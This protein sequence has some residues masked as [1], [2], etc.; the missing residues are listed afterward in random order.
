MLTRMAVMMLALAAGAAA[1]QI[2]NAKVE[3][4]SAAAGLEKAVADIAA[5]NAVA[6]I[7]Y[8]VPAVDDSGVICC[9]GSFDGGRNGCCGTCKLEGGNT[10][11]NHGDMECAGQAESDTI[12]VFLRAAQGRVEKV[13]AF[14][15]NCAVDGGGTIVYTLE[16]VKPEESVALL[17]SLATRSP[18]EERKLASGAVMAIAM[19]AG[20]AA[21]RALAALITSENRK[22]RKDAA[23]WAGTQRGD[24]GY[25]MLKSAISREQDS[26]VRK[27][28]VFPLAQSK[29][30]A[31]LDELIRVARRDGS[32]SVRGEAIFWLGQK[33]SR[34]ASEAI[35]E[36]I[37][38]DPET[39]VKKKAVFALSNLP[40][41]E[42]V[43]LLIK[44]ARTHAN[45]VVR[46]QAIFWLG[47]SQD[48][49]ALQFFEE[50]LK[51]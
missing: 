46:K 23:F 12:A 3:R 38:N 30:A 22:L 51:N 33:A 27:E 24:A 28:F 39:Q 34:K 14:T 31:A 36:A 37:E 18:A 25:A 6:W 15:P 1:Q 21:D 7:A 17:R 4:A 49:R 2:E 50:V 5:K 10:F 13:R 32:S 20:A 16:A 11:I 40:N 48:P 45:P 44:L 35:T 47:Q 8:N 29:A 42:G 43:P 9:G 26:D 19:H 41:D